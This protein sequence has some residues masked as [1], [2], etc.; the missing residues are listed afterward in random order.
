MSYVC[1]W[2]RVS[3]TLRAGTA[4]EVN[5]ADWRPATFGGDQVPRAILPNGTGT[6]YGPGKPSG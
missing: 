2:S 1:I 6:Q 3:N 5:S 4:S